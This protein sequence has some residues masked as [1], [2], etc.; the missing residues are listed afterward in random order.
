MRCAITLFVPLAMLLAGCGRE[1]EPLISHGKPVDH[2]LQELKKPDVK[3]RK[4]AVVA[5]GHVGAADSRAIPALIDSVKD[6][7]AVVRDQAILALLNIGPDAEGAISVLREAE[8]DKNP[9]VRFHATKALERIQ[10]GK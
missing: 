3:S 9:T 1:E 2:W 10:G 5:L 8:N 6:G 4:K 7:D